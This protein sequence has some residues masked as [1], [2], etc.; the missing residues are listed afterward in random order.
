MSPPSQRPYRKFDS[1]IQK[2]RKPI[3]DPVKFNQLMQEYAQSIGTYMMELQQR[4]TENV[5]AAKRALEIAEELTEMEP[6]RGVPWSCKCQALYLL[7]RLPEA[8]ETNKRAL[9]IDPSD[10]EK[11]LLQGN[12]LTALGRTREAEAAFQRAKELT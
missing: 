10:P 2:T 9:E 4:R 7:N 12:M 1:A 3:E 5:A 11:W 6:Q 8:V